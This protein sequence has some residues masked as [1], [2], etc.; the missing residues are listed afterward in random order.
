MLFNYKI[1][2]TYKTKIEPLIQLSKRIYE[3]KKMFKV[4]YEC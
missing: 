1:F 3:V 4:S 2:D